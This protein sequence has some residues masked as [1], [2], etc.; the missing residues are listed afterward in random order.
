MLL[1]PIPGRSWALRPVSRVLLLL[2]PEP[3]N[4]PGVVQSSFKSETLGLF[5]FSIV[6]I[7]FLI[8][9]TELAMVGNVDVIC[10]LYEFLVTEPTR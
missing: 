2:F 9:R 6:Y 10:H 4:N 7:Q 1:I 3:Q 5:V 8:K